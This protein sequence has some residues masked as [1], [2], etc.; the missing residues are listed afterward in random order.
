MRRLRK[1]GR[2]KTKKRISTEK[3]KEQYSKIT[4]KK[5][6]G[7]RIVNTEEANFDVI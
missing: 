6:W 5:V 2:K 1:Q 7:K 4:N 3:E